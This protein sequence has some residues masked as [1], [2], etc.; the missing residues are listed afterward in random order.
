MREPEALIGG[1]VQRRIDLQVVQVGEDRLLGYA[2]HARQ[3]GEGQRIVAL[4]GT[5]KPAIEERRH[6][7]VAAALMGSHYG[8][9]VLVDE[10][11]HRLPIVLLQKHRQ[12]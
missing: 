2:L 10:H 4:E 9:I 12:P 8:R 7:I 6:L 3:Y 5:R 11:D 1:D